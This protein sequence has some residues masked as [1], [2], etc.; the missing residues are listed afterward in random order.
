MVASDLSSKWFDHLVPLK[1]N[2]VPIQNF[3]VRWFIIS[4]DFL[5][6]EILCP[7]W[8]LNP[9][10]VLPSEGFKNE[11]MQISGVAWSV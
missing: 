1:V 6:T 9:Y 11:P 4:W 7:G 2:N 5:S 3:S 10:E 8:D